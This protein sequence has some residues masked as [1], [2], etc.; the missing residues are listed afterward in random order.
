MTGSIISGSTLELE[1]QKE[2][3]LYFEEGSM[4][5]LAIAIQ[6]NCVAFITDIPRLG[7]DP[8]SFAVDWAWS[9]DN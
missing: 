7:Q 3:G 8:T 5:R 4:N 2:P 6:S 9:A 1:P